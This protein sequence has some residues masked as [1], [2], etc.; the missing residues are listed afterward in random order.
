MAKAYVLIVNDSGTED[1]VLSNLIKLETIKDAYGTFGQ[2]DILTKLE[3][4]NNEVIENEISQGIRKIQK[5]RSTLTLLVNE[6]ESFSKTTKLENEILE[7]H[8]AQA[9]VIIH[10]SKSY[11][12]NVLQ[13]LKEI[14]EVISADV[15][16][17]SYEIICKIIAPTYNDISEIITKK[18][19]KLE[20]IKGTI[21][22]NVI[23]NQGF[24]K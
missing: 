16:I 1:S 4:N 22:L 11:E 8:S 14:S 19:R 9:F 18:I 21:T 7:K 6:Q 23:Q 5:I 13:K 17:G 20:N 15:L 10:C 3:S 12:P 24:S 2:Y